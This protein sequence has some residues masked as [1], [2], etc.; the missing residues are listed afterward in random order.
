MINQ[1][2]ENRAMSQKTSGQNLRFERRRAACLAAVFILL[3]SASHIAEA[4]H[5]VS[6]YKEDWRGFFGRH[7]AVFLLRYAKRPPAQ[8][9][10]TQQTWKASKD[11]TAQAKRAPAP[12]RDGWAETKNVAEGKAN[13][14]ANE[15]VIEV[16][17]AANESMTRGTPLTTT[18]ETPQNVN[19]L[20]LLAQAKTIFVKSN[21]L[22]VKRKSIEDSLMK[23]K[24]FLEMGYAVVKDLSEAD[25]KLE[26]DHTALT[27]RYPYTVTHLRT[28]VV[29]AT[30]TVHS[31]R[32]LNDVPGDTA[33]SFVKQAKAARIATG[34]TA[35]KH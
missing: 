22:W 3:F 9:Q 27:L 15:P 35:S 20:A 2:K 18:Q 34:A 29:V 8:N 10:S 14:A 24:G 19:P 30:G 4:Q 16:K 1:Q 6:L 17:V 5:P 13:A 28:Q 11:A 21:S 23:K 33:D 12:A 26:V 32:I 25:L 7:A 31:L